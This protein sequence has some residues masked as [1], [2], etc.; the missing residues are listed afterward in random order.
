MALC[1]WLPVLLEPSL[2]PHQEQSLFWAANS[3]FMVNHYKSVVCVTSSID[4]W[5]GYFTPPLSLTHQQCLPKTPLS[6][7]STHLTGPLF[8][9]GSFQKLS[10]VWRPRLHHTDRCGGGF[11]FS[12]IIWNPASFFHGWQTLA[13]LKS[14]AKQAFCRQI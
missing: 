9:T 3:Y 10:P 7:G 12:T 5:S 11:N 4:L 14:V 6:R 1:F 2:E 8:N 13:A